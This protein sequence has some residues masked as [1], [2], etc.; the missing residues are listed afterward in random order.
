MTLTPQPPPLPY[1][2][3]A[4]T[5]GRSSA[6]RASRGRSSTMASSPPC[7]S[8]RPVP[9]ASA[10]IAAPSTK[11]H[12]G[13]HN[14]RRS[15][16]REA[17]PDF[18]AQTLDGAVVKVRVEREGLVFHKYPQVR[19]LPAQVGAVHGCQH[20][21]VSAWDRSARKGG[22]SPS[23]STRVRMCGCTEERS[24]RTLARAW[25]GTLR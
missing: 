6:A 22:A 18:R 11:T 9:P 23:V 10:P 20:P 1:Q 4:V 24:G 14:A 21:R 12:S 5:R 17:L 7:A 15:Y 13:T 8:P 19:L 2:P 16:P 25:M 3:P